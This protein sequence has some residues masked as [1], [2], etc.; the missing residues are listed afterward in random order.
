[1]AGLA[2]SAEGPNAVAERDWRPVFRY[3]GIP[4]FRY[5][6]IPVFRWKCT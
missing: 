2:A 5:S 3:S 1:V 4:V 6:G